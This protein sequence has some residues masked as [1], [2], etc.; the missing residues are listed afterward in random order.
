M[1]DLNLR[2]YLNIRFQNQQFLCLE[3][4]TKL[5][6]EQDITPEGLTV[7][8]MHGYNPDNMNMHGIFYAYG[9]LFKTNFNVESFEL[10]HIYPLIC[11]ILDIEPYNDIDGDINILKEILN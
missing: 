6:T 7:S 1:N 10:I 2:N 5:P 11:N 9:P 4:P 3:D 8:G